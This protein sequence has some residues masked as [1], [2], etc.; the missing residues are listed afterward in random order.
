MDD[1]SIAP[2]PPPLSARLE[3]LLRVALGLAAGVALAFLIEYLDPTLRGRREVEALGIPVLA[4]LPR[5]R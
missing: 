5:R 2:V 3:P 4:E 1:P